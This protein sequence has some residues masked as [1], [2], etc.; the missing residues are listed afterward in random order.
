MR[1][2]GE[3]TG[4]RTIRQSGPRPDSGLL[5][6]TALEVLTR[7]APSDSPRRTGRKQFSGDDRRR[8]KGGGGGGLSGEEGRAAMH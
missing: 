6:Q 4:E 5:R 8:R 1:K 2:P 3:P 7:S